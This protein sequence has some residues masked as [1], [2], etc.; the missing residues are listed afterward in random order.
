MGYAS[1]LNAFGVPDIGPLGEGKDR[2]RESPPIIR[3]MSDSTARAQSSPAK[4]EEQAR[5][6]VLIGS[7]AKGDEQALGALYDATISRV[8]GFA[9][10]MVNQAHAAEEIAS[11]VFLQ[12]WRES[13]RY[14]AGRSKVLTWLL[15][16]CR[17]RALDWLRARE[18]NEVLHD[19]PE[20]LV[21]EQDQ[22]DASP[23]DLLEAVESSHALHAALAKLAPVQRQLLGLAF[24][25]GL[26]HQEIAEQTRLPLGTVKSHIRRA[27]EALR[28]HMEVAP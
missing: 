16:M 27:V 2:A 26:S 5:L 25:R 20:T 19:E 11:D 21:D 14:D 17:S 10:R 28:G 24:F 18:T 22:D 1:R 9:L 6:C 7:M 3:A 8:Y 12:A 23:P 15:M 13:R 4:L